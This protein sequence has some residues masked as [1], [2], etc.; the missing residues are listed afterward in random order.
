MT[1][2]KHGMPVVPKMLNQAA[3]TGAGFRTNSGRR[4]ARAVA[5]E[6]DEDV[7][8]LAGNE[9]RCTR[10]V[11][12]GD[13]VESI[14]AASETMPD[15]GSWSVGKEM[16][17]ESPSIVVV[18]QSPHRLHPVF[19]LEE[20]RDVADFEDSSPPHPGREAP[21]RAAPLANRRVERRRYLK[22]AAWSSAGSK[23]AIVARNSS[24]LKWAPTRSALRRAPVARSNLAEI[25]VGAR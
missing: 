11:V 12:G 23:A 22:T 8:A 4:S 9:P 16:D 17:L 3:T 25:E 24:A 21:G 19:V 1:A 7:D 15:C 10:V 14:A 2:S 5:V 13:V 18:D 20:R 6:I